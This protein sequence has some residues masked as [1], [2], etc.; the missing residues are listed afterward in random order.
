MLLKTKGYSHLLE[1]PIVAK[2]SSTPLA[3]DSTFILLCE[4]SLPAD[5][6]FSGEAF[7][8]NL[9]QSH[10]VDFPSVYGVPDFDHLMDG[11]IVIV[12]TDG[13]INTLYR[14]HSQQNFLLLTERCNSNCLMCSQPP[15][16]R[17]DSYL[18]STYKKLIPMIPK[19]CRELGLTGGE[20]TLLGDDFFNILDWIQ[21]SLP[22]TQ[23][24]CLTN[25]RSFA[26]SNM[27]DQLGTMNLKQLM[28]GI[29]LYSDY[30]AL[31]DYIVQAKDAFNQTM[32]G[33]YN[34]ARNGQRIEIR[35]VLHQ[36]TIPR[37]VELAKFIYKNLPF[38]EHI[39]FM[40]LEN[41]GYTPH[42][43]SKL[44]IDPVEYVG[45]LTEAVQFL[46]A[47]G[48]T[49]SIYNSQLCLIPAELWEFNRKSISDW[50]N[51]YLDECSRCAKI[52]ECGGLFASAKDRH[53]DY[54][55]PFDYIEI[56]GSL[57]S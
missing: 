32:K 13:V 27:A 2:V 17:D 40:G 50:K 51:I 48:M 53:S 14:I 30:Y 5:Y 37:L 16:D 15:R 39:A 43:I 8:T 41:Q 28:L 19:D 57:K 49:V 44:W 55:K 21:F 20:P 18:I 36:Q 29:P 54:I 3:D 52:D 26:W 34:L 1:E 33:F 42:N 25:G 56:S 31:H 24:H 46:H 23:I 47:M 4:N 22:E 6:M 35:I 10:K 45:Q 38:A 11:D 7:L 12:N 9:P